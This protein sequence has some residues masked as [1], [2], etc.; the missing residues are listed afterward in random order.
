MATVNTQFDCT[1]ETINEFLER[2]IVIYDDKLL[3]AGDDEIKKG[4]VLLKALPVQVITDLQRRIT[5]T[6]LSGV[7][8]DTIKQKLIGQYQTKKSV[9]AASVKFLNYKQSKDQTIEEFAKCVNDLAANCK[10]R[11]CC[12]DRLLRDV[13]IAGLHSDFILRTILQ[14]TEENTFNQCVDRAKLIEQIT[15]DATDIKAEGN[16]EAGSAFT[17]KPDTTYV[18]IR[19]AARGQHFANKC[20][21]I[22]WTCKKCQ[23]KGHIAKACRNSTSTKASYRLSEQHGNTS[24]ARVRTS[25]GEH[26]G[27]K[28]YDVEAFLE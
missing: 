23:K 28:Q 8:Y 14:D 9:V 19:C 1:L 10:F 7:T 25:A 26:K 6:K 4:R 16:L 20:Y 13:F 15:V 2:F 12:R 24:G 18:C 22:N 3:E 17:I 21:A 11:D 5:P 27:D